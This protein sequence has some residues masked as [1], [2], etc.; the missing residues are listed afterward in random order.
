MELFSDQPGDEGLP[1]AERRLAMAAVMIA[2]TM[3]VFDGTIVNVALPQITRELGAPVGTS[4]WVANGYLLATAVTLAIF[5]SLS[6]RVGFRALFSAGLAVFTLTSLGCALSP[7]VEMLIAMRVLQGLG[8]AAMLSIAPAIHRTVFPNRLLGRILGLNAV[9]IATATAVGPA[10]GGTLLAAMGWQ[11][12]FAI[13]VPL[14]LAAV[15]L[16]WRAI[17]ATRVPTREPFDL[18][19]AVLSAIAMGAMILAA[20]ACAQLAHGGQEGRGLL[21]AVGLGLTSIAAALAFMRVQRR[22]RQ[23]LLPLDIFA[24]QRFSLAAL[25]SLVSFVG[26]GIAFVALPFLFQ[27]AYGYSAFESALLF[28]PWPIGI[29]LVAPHA[30]RLADRHSPALLSTAGLALFA[31]GLALLAL[32]PDQAQAWDIAWRALVCGMGFGFFQ[33]PNNREMLGNVSRERS[34]N[35]SG[36]LAIMRTFGQCLG[37]AL[38][39]IVLSVYAAAAMSQGHAQMNAAEDAMAIRFALWVAVAATVVATFVSCSRIRAAREAVRG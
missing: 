8:A 14:G 18:A 19:G 32:L 20:E 37:T 11:W 4:I 17:P 23:P 28:T 25:T 29:V 3:A 39:G 30:G 2:T 12:L 38:L 1:G 13:N 24:S 6:G 10:L 16:S 5:A 33:S 27:N 9:L 34:G 21:G 15:W 26:Q 31:V 35:A 36:V 7:T 22:A